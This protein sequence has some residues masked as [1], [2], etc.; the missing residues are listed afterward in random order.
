MH[1]RIVGH[2]HAHLNSHVCIYPSIVSVGST[3]LSKCRA[4]RADT[5]AISTTR[6]GM[7]WRS[8]HGAFV[9]PFSSIRMLHAAK[10]LLAAAFFFVRDAFD[11]RA[12]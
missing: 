3:V 9:L 8:Q 4:L 11:A 1:A 2:V 7:E 10:P 6:T 5:L 12:R